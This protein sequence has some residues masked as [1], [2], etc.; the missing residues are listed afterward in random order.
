MTR[1]GDEARRARDDSGFRAHA[2]GVRHVEGDAAGGAAAEHDIARADADEIVIALLQFGGDAHRVLHLQPVLEVIRAGDAR[3]ERD[4]ARRLGPH[5]LGDRHGKAQP[6]LGVPA[7]FVRAFVGDGTVKFMDQIAMRR[8]HLD[9]VEAETDGAPRRLREGVDGGVDFRVVELRRHVP[10][11]AIGQRRGRDGAPR[12][13][14][15]AQRPAAHPVHMGRGLA[16]RVR[17]L[18]AE[19]RA[20][21]GDGARGVQHPPQRV[22]A[23][24]GIKAE[25][26]V[27]DA[28][29]ARHARRFQND[30]RRARHGVVHDELQVPV[31]RA[32]VVGRI[33][34][35]GRDGDAVGHAHG[36]KIKR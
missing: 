4:A 13:F 21:Q 20:G 27:R 23:G 33:L 11:L 28:P 34:A 26:A 10:V 5:G 32:A 2:R 7:P 36:A 9:D 12:A 3:A 24:V 25:A 15:G 17:E 14:A 1:L 16:A 31:R 29:L 6:P 8:V 30:R 35:H 18:D 22:F 19:F